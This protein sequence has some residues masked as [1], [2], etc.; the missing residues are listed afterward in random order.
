MNHLKKIVIRRTLIPNGLQSKLNYTIVS[1]N[2]LVI[3]KKSDM[4]LIF[5]GTPE[6]GIPSLKAAIDSGSEVSAVFT[7]PDRRVGRKNQLLQSPIKQFAKKEHLR[8]V[9]P[10]N[11]GS[12]EVLKLTHSL[13]PELI[14]VCAYGQI[15]NES[16]L[17][18]P[19]IGCFNLH[20]SFLPKFRGASPVQTSISQGIKN[21]GVSL[22]KM[23]MRLDAGPIIAS[24]KPVEIK[25][26]DTS[27][28]LGDRLSLIGGQLIRDTLP[29]LLEENFNE[30][31]QNEKEATYC[32]IIKKQEGQIKWSKESA[33]EIE[34]KA[35]AFEP[36]P[37]IFSFYQPSSN[38]KIVRRIKLTKVEVVKG[39]FEAGK[40]YPEFIV[41]TISGG[42]KILRLKP[43]GKNEMDSYS[44]LRGQPD[45]VG[46]FLKY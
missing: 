14:L 26:N 15:L 6:W 5:M 27:I 28:S 9:S 20:F 29:K 38:S 30:I 36:W 24:S 33:I 16:F 18:I 43:E 19:R 13:S 42:L 37:G 7:Q 31:E 10:E 39:N 23:T 1:N 3:F 8:V 25:S 44:F 41:G 45:V 4:S 40:I 34:R 35:R 21:T 32:K 17:K 11:T 12:S 22:Q 2:Y 46:T